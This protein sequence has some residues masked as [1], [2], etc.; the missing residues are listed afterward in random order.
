MSKAFTNVSPEFREH[1]NS[2]P[3]RI[4]DEVL[5]DWPST[6]L[7]VSHPDSLDKR[8]MKFRDRLQTQITEVDCKV[9]DGLHRI[10]GEHQTA[11]SQEVIR[12]VVSETVKIAKGF[13]PPPLIRQEAIKGL[14]TMA[15][16]SDKQA[17]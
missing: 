9:I 15:L 11:V 10:R 4:P 16:V 3:Y 14:D 6:S 8:Q 1:W 7:I 12:Y 5:R 2:D 17:V 13:T